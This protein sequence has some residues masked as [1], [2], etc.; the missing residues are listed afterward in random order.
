MRRA[1]QGGLGSGR[2]HMRLVALVLGDRGGADGAGRDL[3]LACCSRAASNSGSP[4]RARTMLENTVQVARASYDREVER[5]ANETVDRERRPCRL[6]AQD[7]DRRSALPGGVRAQPG[8]QPQPLRS[9]HLHL[10]RRT[11]RS[12]PSRWSI[13]TTGR[14]SKDI[15]PRQHCRA[16]S[17]ARSCRIN[18]PDRIGAVTNIDSART[19]IFTQRACSTRSS[20]ADPAAPM[21]SST[22]I[23]RCW[24]NRGST[25]CASTPRCC[26]AR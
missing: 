23:R 3:R 13:R 17:N 16:Q 11:S 26:L 24:P 1:E 14:S 10:R 12:G 20:A 22:T 18:S 8:A 6:S 15:P 2:L 9:D 19:P 4:N 7:D 21:T 25:S 5:V